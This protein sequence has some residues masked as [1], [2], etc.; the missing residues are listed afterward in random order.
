[1]LKLAEELDAT[2]EHV[3]KIVRGIGFPSKRMLKDICSALD[4]NFE[5]MNRLAVSDRIEKKYGSVPAEISGKTPRFIKLERILPQ[6]S[7]EQFNML[8]A[9]A[10]GL[11]RANRR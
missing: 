4:L 11:A 10:E 8:L 5:E 2:Y 6:L 3:R 7:D 1:V 9:S